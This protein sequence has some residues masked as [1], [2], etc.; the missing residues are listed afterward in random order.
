M[1][2]APPKQ[3]S[4]QW[5]TLGTHV[6]LKYSRRAKRYIGHKRS[7]HRIGPVKVHSTFDASLQRAISHGRPSTALHIKDR[8]VGPDPGKQE[9]L[10]RFLSTHGLSSTL[11]STGC[12]AGR[13]AGISAA[14][15]QHPG[16]YVLEKET[17]RSWPTAKQFGCLTQPCASMPG[18]KDCN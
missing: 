14:W 10:T 11:A 1:A 15:L 18:A 17:G 6:N 8:Q 9:L 16:R 7:F 12:K 3:S 4:K 2:A 13:N 5:S